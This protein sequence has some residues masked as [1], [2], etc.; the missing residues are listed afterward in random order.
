MEI[1]HPDTFDPIAKALECVGHCI[2]DRT[3]DHPLTPEL[4]WTHLR[5]DGF[6]IYG[7][8]P[9]PTE[10][11]LFFAHLVL[12]HAFGKEMVGGNIAQHHYW[13][14]RPGVVDVGMFES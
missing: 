11:G 5:E 1:R 12:D 2:G 3:E 4:F 8:T 13:A 10:L 6:A 14:R 9:D 7:R